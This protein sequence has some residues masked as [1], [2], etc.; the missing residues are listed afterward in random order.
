MSAPDLHVVGFAG[1]GGSSKAYQLAGIRVNVA[2]N[3]DREALAMHFRNNAQ[4]KHYIEDIRTINPHVACGGRKPRSAWFSPDCRDFSKAK[5]GQPKSKRVRGLAWVIIH[6]INSLGPLAPDVIFLENVEEFAHWCSLLPNGQRNPW[7]KGWFFRCFV[8][9]LR[10]RGYVVEW[11]EQRACDYGAPT[12]RKRLFLV[13]RRD[14]Q[15]IVWPEPTHGAPDSAEV[16]SG[17][18]LPY[19]TAAECI[20]FGLPCPS[21]FMTRREAQ[22]YFRKTGIRIQRPL[23]R[24]SLRRIALGVWRHAMTAANPFLVTLNHGGGRNHAPRSIDEPMRTVTAARDAHALVSP[25]LAYGQHGGAT[26]DARLPMH[27]IAASTKDTN[28]V[29]AV[30]I[31]KLRGA[32]D[33]HP[34]GYDVAEPLHTISADGNHHGVF[35]AYLAQNNGGANGHQSYGHACTE[36]VSTISGKGSNQSLIALSMV[37]Y[38]GADQ[39]PQMT[40]PLHSVTTKDRFGLIETTLAIPELTPEL[41]ERARRVARFLRRFGVEFEGEFATVAG[42]VIYD[43]GMRMLIARELYRAQGFPDDYVID[44]GWIEEEDGTITEIILSGKAQVRMCGNSV[45]P[46]HAAALIQANLGRRMDAE[47]AA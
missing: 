17:K 8:G 9:A 11:R 10:R 36:P 4:A 12:I 2:M 22:R 23:A 37:K 34:P 45:S 47:L 3:H 33:S 18:L 24:A 28:A 41:A 1:G 6:W 21:I 40:E 15:P 39:D 19:R 26:R 29:V 42:R 25:L 35:A 27:T 20:E 7:R 38:Y 43:I 46:V 31:A 32:P 14:G 44:R 16:K 13:A 5:Q 30:S